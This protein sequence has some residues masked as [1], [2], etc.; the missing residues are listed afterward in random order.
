MYNRF[1]LLSGKMLSSF[2]LYC[3]TFYRIMSIPLKYTNDS[4]LSTNKSKKQLSDCVVVT[5]RQDVLLF[6][7]Y[8]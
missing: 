7:K 2:L 3:F 8:F 4:L 1:P 5:A 6:L